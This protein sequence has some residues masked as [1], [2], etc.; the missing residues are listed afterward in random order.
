MKI[1]LYL[2]FVLFYS[3]FSHKGLAQQKDKA[4]IINFK[5]FESLT[6]SFTSRRQPNMPKPFLFLFLLSSLEEIEMRSFI[7]PIANAFTATNKTNYF[8]LKKRARIEDVKALRID[9][10]VCVC[11]CVCR[12]AKERKMKEVI[13]SSKLYMNYIYVCVSDLAT[14][15][16]QGV[17]PWSS[18]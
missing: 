16:V 5:T 14:E 9:I 8:I 1:Q 17:T 7:C 18:M 3:S 11:V 10:I 15:R 13:K 2:N 6:S 12:G 4:K